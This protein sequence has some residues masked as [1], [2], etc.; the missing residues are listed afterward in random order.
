MPEILNPQTNPGEPT[1][2]QIGHQGRLGRQWTDW[3]EGLTVTPA[4][5]GEML[6]TGPVTD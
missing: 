2:Y 3:F 5:N 4:D 1:V 6:L